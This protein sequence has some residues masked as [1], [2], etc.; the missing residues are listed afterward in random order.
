MQAMGFAAMGLSQMMVLLLAVGGVGIPLGMPPEKEDPNL[1]FVA[2]EKCLLYATWSGMAKPDASSKNHTEQLLAEPELARFAKA[3]EE[4]LVKVTAQFGQ[5]EDPRLKK[6]A[7][8]VPLWSRSILT[9]PTAIF[10]TK[11]APK[12][13][14][15]DVEAGLIVKADADAAKMAQLLAVLLAAGEPGEASPLKDVTIGGRKFHQ[16]PPDPQA[17]PVPMTFGADAQYFYLSLGEG[18]IDKMQARLAAKKTP[19]WLTKVRENLPV[20]RRASLS[21]VDVKTI[22]ETLLPLAGPQAEPIVAALGLNQIQTLEAVTGLD[23]EGIVSKSLVSIDGQ[24]RGLLTLLE[25]PGIKAANLKHIPSDAMF[26]T[27]V[28]IDAAKTFDTI[29]GLV[30]ELGGPFAARQWEESLRGLEDASGI[31]L[32]EELLS[33]VGPTWTISM[34]AAD[35]WFTGAVATV[36]VKDKAKL[37][38]AQE[39]IIALAKQQAGEFGGQVEVKKSTEN[40]QEVH[41]V[42][43]AGGFM[44]F[45]PAWCITDKQLVVSFFPQTVRAILSRGPAEKSLADLPEVAAALAGE[46]NVVAVT[47]YDAQRWFESSYPY[48]Q[49]L[50]PMMQAGMSEG[51][52][53]LGSGGPPPQI[54]DAAM[55]PSARSIHRHL[56]PGVTVVRRTPRGLESTTRQTLPTANV[57]ATAPVAVALLLPAVQAARESARRMQS[58]NNL[59]QI[60]IAV[61]NHH[62]VWRALPASHSLTKDGKPGLSWRV[63]ILPYVEQQPLYDQFHLDEPW[64][65]EHNKALIAKM[66]D[67]YKSPTSRA[68]EGKTVYL[69]VKGKNAAFVPP[70]DSDKGKT[71]PPGISLAAV[72]DG[73]SNTI[74]VVEAGDEKAA[75]W[76]K[77]DD[78]E[79]DDK[80]PLKG[81]VNPG[82]RG[83]NAAFC[84][85]A[86]RLIT[87]AVDAKTLKRLFQRNDGE[88]V[89][90]PE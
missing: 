67:V 54:F 73:T 78:F 71:N 51:F 50:L 90:I 74:M 33:A 70:A 32:K 64:D 81:L 2:P 40:G 21:F 8:M 28:S 83:F 35:G 47:Y 11:L 56:R 61:H 86:V 43:V 26:A 45:Q 77:P 7:E 9:R 15:V 85:G 57:G 13:N 79:P 22:R 42:S 6:A 14:S 39:K 68:G 62:D 29:D 5:S 52:R 55:L 66:P 44:P 30:R 19:A 41:Y 80:D 53:E 63:H 12:D 46:G 69:G 1:A 59:R 25:G 65:S 60:G 27:S 4:S 76:T 49:M 87:K 36:D 88:P 38:A 75:V 23:G 18:V 34:S 17:L 3:L 37:V 10:V 89:E 20:E 31:R 24:S 84:D 58:Q 72:V 48:V 82:G 16:L